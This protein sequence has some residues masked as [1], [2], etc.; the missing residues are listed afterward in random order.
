MCKNDSIPSF[1]TGEYSIE[2]SGSKNRRKHRD[3]WNMFGL[4]MYMCVVCMY[5]YMYLPMYI[6]D[7]VEME[8]K[9]AAE[10]SD[11]FDIEVCECAIKYDS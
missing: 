9:A 1:T 6:H 11:D 4:G 8:I 3:F 5:I 7:T 10:L 2:T